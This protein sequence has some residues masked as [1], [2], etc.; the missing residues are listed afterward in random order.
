MNRLEQ[1][2][3]A[4]RM[5]AF[6]EALMCDM[7]GDVI[8][9]TRT[10]LFAVIN[11]E[12]QTPLLNEVG[13][14]GVMRSFILS[15]CKHEGIPVKENAIRQDEL[16]R[17][18]EIFV[19]NGVLGIWPVKQVLSTPLRVGPTTLRLANLIKEKIVC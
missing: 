5:G 15:L 1:V 19:C 8:E 18:S 12:L 13:I 14:K 3:A 7:N 16:I 10:N 11:N 4:S 6:D 17:A 2:M 9:G